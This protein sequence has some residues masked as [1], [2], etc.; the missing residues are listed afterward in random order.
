[1]SLR[2]SKKAA[3]GVARVAFRGLYGIFCLAKRRDEVL[4]V[5]RKSGEPSYDY[6][7]CGKAFQAR[8]YQ[9]VY[10]S[11]HF[12]KS[13][14]LAYAGL[15]LRELNHL[16][17]CKVCVIDRYDPVISLLDFTCEPTALR[18]A[19]H[20]EFPAVPVVIQLWHA[21]GAFKKFGYQ[22]IDVAEGHTAEEAAAF[23]IHRNN[24]WVIC[25]GEGARTAF[26]EAF[27]C[28]VER[29]LPIGRP[30]Y[31]KLC[32]MRQA[33]QVDVNRA[34]EKATVLFAPTI[35]KYDKAADPFADL[36]GA[37]GKLF[38]S[39]SYRVSWSLH[40]LATGKDAGGDV[41]VSL[42]DADIIITDYSSIVYEAY[43]LGK[44]VGFYIPDIQYYRLSPGLNADPLELCPG[45][46]ADTPEQLAAMLASWAAEPSAYPHQQLQRFVG[47]SF[48]NCAEDPA[49]ELATFAIQCAKG[50][51]ERAQ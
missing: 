29:V 34:S 20:L 50:G 9:P 42:I 44:L 1:M 17:R 45:L 13:S 47:D 5:S 51:T 31:R 6:L 40:P 18:G 49:G 33:A 43:L 48:A 35:R 7:E 4:F 26:A 23:R 25:S 36:R 24:S 39:G 8:G 16:A 30:E 27:A 32:D 37:A 28:P 21:F 14:A 12:K 38:Q 46:V 10:L 22:A 41:P 11:Q 15:V 19:Q 3:A 2:F